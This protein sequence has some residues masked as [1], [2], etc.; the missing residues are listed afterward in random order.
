LRPHCQG[1]FNDN[2]KLQDGCR[3]NGK[4]PYFSFLRGPRSAPGL[5]F[6]V[7]THGGRSTFCSREGFFFNNGHTY[8]E[9]LWL[10]NTAS[11]E[12]LRKSIYG[13]KQLKI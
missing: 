4:S 2:K 11:G 7:D 13:Q 3:I 1:I 6:Y 5:H 10:E 8:M 12:S 9:S